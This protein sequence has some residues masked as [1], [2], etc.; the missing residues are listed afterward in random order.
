M[1]RVFVIAEAGVNHNGNYDLACQLIDIAQRCGADAVK[2]QTFR[3]EDLVTAEAPAAQYQ[4]RNAGATRQFDML[5]ELELPAEWH[6]RLKQHAKL[7][8]IEFF[9]TPF[10]ESAIDLLVEVGVGRLKLPSGEITNKPL[11]QHAARTGL[12][13]IVS[14]GM[15]TLEEVRVAIGWILEVWKS[16]GGDGITEGRLCIL[17]CTS[18]Y[19]ASADTLNLRAI[20][21]LA[22]ELGLEVGYSDHSEGATA[23]IAAVALGA[24]VIE[25]HITFDREASGPDHLASS[26]E[27]EF[28]IYVQAIRAATQMMGNGIKVPNAAE[29][30]TLSVARRSVVAA[31][32]LTA[33]SVLS[34]SDLAILRP[35]GGLPPEERDNLVG[36]TLARDV[37]AG[38]QLAWSDLKDSP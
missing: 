32:D 21:T 27:S 4:T 3:A 26:N 20:T 5:R 10:S 17:H 30:D 34:V 31:R 9:S 29:M 22:V 13:L 18:N 7:R 11:L 37:H 6:N 33:G 25:K 8:G 12:P 14:T 35:A 28:A 23:A 36:Q 24:T 16:Q 2:F 19:P 1:T 38:Q 15:A